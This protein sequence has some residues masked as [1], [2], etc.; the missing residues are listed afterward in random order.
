MPLKIIT[1]WIVVSSLI[2]ACQEPVDISGRIDGTEQEASTIYIIEP[3]SLRGV[4]AAYFGKVIDSAVVDTNGHFAF[5]HLPTYE[6][7]Q[8][9]E[10]AI[11][12]AGKAPNYLQ[13]DD[14]SL[15]NYMPIIWQAGESMVISAHKDHFQKSFSISQPSA[16]NRA[17]ID[18]RDVHLKAY[19]N[20]IA[21]Q[22]W[23]IEDGSGL[24]EKEQATSRYQSELIEYADNSAYLL[25]AIVA[26]RWVS[27]EHYYERVPEFLVR[28]CSKWKKEQLNHPWVDE[29]CQA[30]DPAKLPVLVGDIFPNLTFPTLNGD[31]LATQDQLGEKLTIID[32]WASWC[33]PCRKEN[34]TVLA[35]LWD[36][37]HLQGLQI[38]A[39]GLESDATQW[40]TAVERDGADRWLHGS[41]LQGDD[42]PFLAQ[43]RIQ[44]IPANFILDGEGKV[45]AKNV[46]GSDLIDLVNDHLEMP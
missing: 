15:S 1:T 2:V 12:Q 39:Y 10:I 31:T 35:P 40:R 42:A 16:V 18:L 34:R 6:A 20:H 21:G 44:T 37:Y 9:L 46:H 7:P 36:Q 43:L 33:A 27:P 28:Q 45:V 14:P 11:K 30:G 24:I 8:L 19:Q 25:P 5:N 26:L 29:L 13:T 38:I 17:L 22:Q 23:D 32:L 3:Q 4:A 41:D